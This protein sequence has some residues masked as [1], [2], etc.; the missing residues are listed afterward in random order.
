M[1]THTPEQVDQLQGENI[2]PFK[3][4]VDQRIFRN[5]D[6]DDH[7]DE[8]KKIMSNTDKYLTM[9]KYSNSKDE[10]NNSVN[11]MIEEERRSKAYSK[12]VGLQS[13][14]SLVKKF[15]VSLVLQQ[16]I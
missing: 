7:S 13:A 9:A 6:N 2:K 14:Q 15:L 16:K 12:I 4:I 1:D 11:N 5:F 3:L 8:Y 10:N